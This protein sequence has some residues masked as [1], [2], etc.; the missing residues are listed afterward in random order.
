M[1][2]A[3]MIEKGMSEGIYTETQLLTLKN[4][5]LAELVSD[6]SITEQDKT[7]LIEAIDEYLGL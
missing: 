4:T 6:G 5:G 1:S 2:Y 3:E 7:E